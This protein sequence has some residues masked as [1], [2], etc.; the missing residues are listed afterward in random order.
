[1]T[2]KAV[3]LL[4][5]ITFPKKVT[6]AA[7]CDQSGCIRSM[8]SLAAVTTALFPQSIH[9]I[10]FLFNP[11][12]QGTQQTNYSGRRNSNTVQASSI[13]R[14]VHKNACP[15]AARTQTMWHV[16]NL[17]KN[18]ALGQKNVS[19]NCDAMSEGATL[20]HDDNFLSCRLNELQAYAY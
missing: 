12:R 3:E 20:S 15:R 9:D 18:L 8:I 19:C 10:I 1:L 2:F 4:T 6:A 14:F 17:S 7:V 5:N 11:M 13:L 16:F